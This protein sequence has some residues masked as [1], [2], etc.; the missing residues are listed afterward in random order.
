MSDLYTLLNDNDWTFY[1]GRISTAF[2]RYSALHDRIDVVCARLIR[3]ILAWEQHIAADPR[4]TRSLT[5]FCCSRGLSFLV[6]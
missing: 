3:R 6:R 5:M 2:R 4:I 1:R